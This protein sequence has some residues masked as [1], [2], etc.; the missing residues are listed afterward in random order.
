MHHVECMSPLRLRK[1]VECIFNGSNIKVCIYTTNKTSDIIDPGK[2][3]KERKTYAL[4]VED[5][6]KNYNT[7]LKNIKKTVGNK[8][9]SNIIRGLRS[10]KDGKLLVI[11]D[12]DEDAVGKL[13][14]TMES[15]T[16]TIKV[17]R[18]GEATKMEVVHIRGLDAVTK[19]E[20]VVASIETKLGSLDGKSYKLSELRPN[21]GN[22][23]AT[24]LTIN[25]EDAEIVMRDRHVRIG[26][27]RCSTD[28]RINFSRCFKCWSYDH[29]EA[30]CK[31]SN[32]KNLCYKC[33]K[34]GH[35]SKDCK[36]QEACPICEVIGHK[37]GSGKCMNFKRA[38]SHARRKD[39]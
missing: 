2:Q 36:E 6:G 29:K 35:L 28:R 27:V 3:P 25:K 8:P 19:R 37:A 22:T 16:E 39:K 17:R 12:K 5:S 23:L 26:I 30:D 33:G 32:R 38:L 18:T 34:D 31:G 13:M 4:A 14:K 20:E 9:V 11:T 15:A 10:T 24:T 21:A 7:V 1:M